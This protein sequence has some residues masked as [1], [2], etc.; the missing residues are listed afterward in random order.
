MWRVGKVSLPTSVAASRTGTG[1]SKWNGSAFYT[2]AALFVLRGGE[3]EAA[4]TG[5]GAAGSCRKIP[6]RSEQRGGGL[7]SGIRAAVEP[8][9]VK[10]SRNLLL[11]L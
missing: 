7:H 3:R 4:V 8:K 6:R 10:V 1:L 9:A 2:A 11:D 5:E